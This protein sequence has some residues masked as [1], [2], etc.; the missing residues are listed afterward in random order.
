MPHRPVR[1][2]MRSDVVTLRPDQT[3]REA[4]QVL[5]RRR[6]SGA[7]VVDA[8][9]HVLGVVSQSDLVRFDADPPSVTAAGTFFSDVE[10]YRDLGAMPAD[11]GQVRVE[12]LMSRS[13]IAVAPEAPLT[14]VARLLRER[15]VHR[16]LVTED[17]RL[18]GIV[19]ALDLLVAIEEAGGPAAR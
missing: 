5:A 18:R 17:G 3:A 7:P 10:E 1:D 15:R 2:V 9:G 12:S 16:V 4:E 19:S 8:E 11:E 13:V 6:V 14:E